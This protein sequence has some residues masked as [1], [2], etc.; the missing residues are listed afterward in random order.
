MC[1]N[2]RGIE[3][4]VIFYSGWTWRSFPTSQPAQHQSVNERSG[5]TCAFLKITVM[6]HCWVL[7]LRMTENSKC[8]KPFLKH[9][10]HDAADRA[11]AYKPRITTY[12]CT[13]QQ[14]TSAILSSTLFVCVSVYANKTNNVNTQ[15]CR[16]LMYSALQS[17]HHR[18][19][20]TFPYLVLLQPEN[21]MDI[22]L[23][24]IIKQPI[25]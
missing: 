5:N 25:I 15:R 10:S 20:G 14:L 3:V 2:S 1:C 12:N 24:E 11:Q 22:N 23:I 21:E 18:T 16:H 8:L 7:W 19:P 13:S 6:L 17:I 9:D 4:F